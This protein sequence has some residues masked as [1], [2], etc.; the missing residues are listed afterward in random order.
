MINSIWREQLADAV[1]QRNTAELADL[2]AYGCE[3][4][5]GRE[6]GTPEQRDEWWLSERA[7][8]IRRAGM[9]A[10][11]GMDLGQN[12]FIAL[13]AALRAKRGRGR[14]VNQLP[15]RIKAARAAQGVVA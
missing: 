13:L 8:S 12:E 2:M 6:W 9:D 15:K 4:P 7:K 1:S 5:Q 3:L 10:M 14:L 11:L